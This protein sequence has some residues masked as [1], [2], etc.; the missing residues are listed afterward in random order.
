MAER[1]AKSAMVDSQKSGME[2]TNLT[3]LQGPKRFSNCPSAKVNRRQS[4]V[5]DLVPGT[6]L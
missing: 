3:F 6:V 5:R 1:S 4:A 2:T